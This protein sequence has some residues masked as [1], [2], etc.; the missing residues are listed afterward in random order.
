MVFY[1][2]FFE[3]VYNLLQIFYRGSVEEK[4][5]VDREGCYVIDE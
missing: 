5:V 4:Y 2:F 1:V 3:F